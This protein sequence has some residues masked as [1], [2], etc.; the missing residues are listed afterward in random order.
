[1]EIRGRDII[2]CFF[3]LEAE[4]WEIREEGVYIQGEKENRHVDLDRVEDV[5]EV[6]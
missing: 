1:M 2:A 4:E 6:I 3:R 5:D